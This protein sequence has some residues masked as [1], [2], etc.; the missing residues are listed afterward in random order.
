MFTLLRNI[1]DFRGS[2]RLGTPHRK[3]GHGVRS[4]CL[5]FRQALEAL[6]DR[7]A[8]SATAQPT[9][10]EPPPVVISSSASGPTK[11]T[12]STIKITL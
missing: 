5:A 2:L 12:L 6:E 3:P 11:N 4:P 7:M 8:P 10:T 9:S 1:V